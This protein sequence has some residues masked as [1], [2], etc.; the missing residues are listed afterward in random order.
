MK[1]IHSIFFARRPAL[2]SLI[3]YRSSI[4]L[5]VPQ[6]ILAIACIALGIFAYPLIV[7]PIFKKMLP[8]EVVGIWRPELAT[9][10]II[11]GILLGLLIY[12]ISKVKVRITPPFIGGEEVTPE[13]RVSGTDF[14]LTIREIG[15]F[16]KIYRWAEKMYFDI[17]EII[18]K[19]ILF[20]SKVFRYTHTGSLPLY[21]LWIAI[22]VAI[23]LVIM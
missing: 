17:Y 4:L 22:G 16:N 12:G 15:I 8:F 20:F 13:M 5:I 23:I 6:L 1:L 11:V 14:Y 21:L 10:L 19:W 18:K 3:T 9:G 7:N 2:S